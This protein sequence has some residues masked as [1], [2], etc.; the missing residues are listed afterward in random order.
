MQHAGLSHNSPTRGSPFGRP[1]QSAEGVVAP[2][3]RCAQQ[4]HNNT[5]CITLDQRA[6]DTWLSVR[7][8]SHTCVIIPPY[9]E[10]VSLSQKSPQ[11]S[12]GP[13]ART[14]TPASRPREHQQG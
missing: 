2:F 14:D 5:C 4:G 6:D 13:Q 12:Y 10:T 7:V 9:E 11:A 3:A 8:T 1:S